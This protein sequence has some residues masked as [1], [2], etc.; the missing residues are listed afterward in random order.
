MTSTHPQAERQTPVPSPSGLSAPSTD[1]HSRAARIVLRTLS[2]LILSAALP[3]A[4]VAEIEDIGRSQAWIVTLGIMIWAGLRLSLLW[5]RGTPRLFDFFFWLF[6][7]I[8]LGIAPT[9]QM[10][11][12]LISTTTQGMDPGLD[13][14]TA[15]VVVLGIACYEIGRLGVVLLEHR[16]HRRSQP[17]VRPVS[18]WRTWMLLG[19]ALVL[20]AYILSRL[21][22][23]IF[24]G[25]REAA[26][27][28]RE[29]AWPDPAMR[30]II[31]ASGVYPLL[32]AVGS[33]VQVRR[34]ADDDSG[35]R[36]WAGIAALG[37]AVVLLMIV[38]P[39]ASARYSFGTVAFALVVFAGAAV[40]RRRARLTM[41]AT[42]AGFLFLFPLADAFRRDDS[43]ASRADFF[44]EYP[45]NPDYDAFWQVSNALSY[46][47]DGL[48]VPL[49]QFLGS[50]LFWVPRA[51]WPSKPSG[52][53]VMLAEYRGYS[54]DN[55]S[56]P[57]WAEAL[58]NGG[59][60]A[61]VILF[62][63]LG[64]ALR[65]MDT[66]IVPALADG[67]VWALAGAILP[68]YMTI[69]L[70]GSLLQATGP[71]A[72]TI[73]CVLLVRGRAQRQARRSGPSQL[74]RTEGEPV[75]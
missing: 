75:A 55:L 69:L 72:L 46:W 34:A 14:P 61:V 2:I 13:L 15:G 4:L 39:V 52:T 42:I 47:I 60:V 21:G 43:S 53:G 54:F 20:S 38:N 67:G 62:L 8:F 24:L 3:A 35:S 16:G 40:T 58:V 5:V 6:V 66:R 73:A 49:N 59:V 48:V 63:V 36:R 19:F 74:A 64:A 50:V 28:A 29:A 18:R 70:R 25:S 1:S 71:L 65:A 56:A 22:A 57:M 37:G 45:S 23:T 32:V 27:A 44:G 10:R 17:A 9:A 41:L 68:V 30:S 51:L 33:L 31:F 7:Y 12:G 11:S 26:G